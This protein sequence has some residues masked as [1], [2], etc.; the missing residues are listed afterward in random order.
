MGFFKLIK[1]VLFKKKNG[2]IGIQLEIKDTLPYSKRADIAINVQKILKPYYD[3]IIT[4]YFTDTKTKKLLVGL[5]FYCYAP[6]Y[7]GSFQDNPQV[8]AEIIE[9]TIT[10][11]SERKIKYHLEWFKPEMEDIELVKE[12]IKNV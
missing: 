8:V 1:S 5:K 6:Y 7:S 12:R 10:F 2:N 9:N 11:F 3:D 4:E